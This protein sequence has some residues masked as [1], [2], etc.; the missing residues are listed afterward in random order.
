M[1]EA[2]TI[3]YQAKNLQIDCRFHSEDITTD[4][5]SRENFNESLAICQIFQFSTVKRL[6]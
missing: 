4:A 3:I 6:C 1:N 5:F 2:Y